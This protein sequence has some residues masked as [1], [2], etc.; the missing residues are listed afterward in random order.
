MGRPAKLREKQRLLFIDL[1]SPSSHL[2]TQ[3]VGQAC[4]KYIM[5]SLHTVMQIC[6]GVSHKL[7]KDAFRDCIYRHRH[8]NLNRGIVNDS[9]PS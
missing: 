9:V 5:R 2:V 6:K 4:Q 3:A 1:E 8:S 7:H